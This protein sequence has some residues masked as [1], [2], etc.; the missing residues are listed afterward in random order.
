[1]KTI[2]VKNSYVLSLLDSIENYLLDVDCDSL[3]IV[4]EE[5]LHL[6][7]EKLSDK[8]LKQIMNAGKSHEGYPL[9]QPM[10]VLPVESFKY[11]H[12]HTTELTE[13]MFS[14]RVC[15]DVLYP[16]KSY[17]SWHNN[18]NAPGNAIMFSWSKTGE[19]DFRYWDNDKKEVMYIPD[20][21][22]WNV[23]F[24]NFGD[25]NQP[26]KLTYHASSNECLRYSMAFNFI[27]EKQVLDETVELLT[28]DE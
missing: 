27:T 11:I 14:E 12:K 19:G 4:Q 28:N 9:F 3:E 17:C 26:E 13:Y 25:Y 2:E 22:G 8:Y 23:K 6:K 24:F 7:D 10:Y 1:M 21:K 20:K 16:P 15:L 18:A 5:F